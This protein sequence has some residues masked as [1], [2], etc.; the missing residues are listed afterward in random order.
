MV[1][2]QASDPSEFELTKG[3][4]LRLI[5][6]ED[7]LSVKTSLEQYLDPNSADRVFKIA[8]SKFH[9][10]RESETL[11]ELQHSIYF[12][13]RPAVAHR[14]RAGLNVI[15]LGVAVTL[16]SYF[17]APPGASY[18]IFVGLIAYGVWLFISS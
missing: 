16:L 14:A 6:G 10:A 17:F 12:A 3:A 15:I 18:T 11:H 2:E 13:K 9:A 7:P 4:I 5:D 1:M 8:F